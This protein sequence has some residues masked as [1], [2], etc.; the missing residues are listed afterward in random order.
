MQRSS[1][2]IYK[3]LDELSSSYIWSAAVLVLI[4]EDHFLFIKRSETM[5]THKGQIGFMGGH[6]SLDEADPR[7]TAFR[8]F[9]EESHISEVYLD[10]IGLMTPVKTTLANVVVPVLALYKESLCHF[11]SNV[12]SNGEWDDYI[13]TPIVSLSNVN[14]WTKGIVI[15]REKLSIFFNSLNNNNSENSM[16]SQKCANEFNYVLWG[17]SAKM[18]CNFFQIHLV[19]DKKSP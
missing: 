5:P 6:K 12:H 10:Y 17:A 9:S 16:S 2:F 13:L 19:D 7:E 15:G 14:S 3:N 8:E 11:K 1:L 18:I 4:I